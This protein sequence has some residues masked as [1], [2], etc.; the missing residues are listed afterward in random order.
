MANQRFFSTLA[1]L[2]DSVI[3]GQLQ[4]IEYLQLDENSNPC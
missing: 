4:E 2:P 1:S 3:L